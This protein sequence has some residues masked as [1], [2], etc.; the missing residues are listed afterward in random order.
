MISLTWQEGFFQA[1]TGCGVYQAR[2]AIIASGT[3]PRPMSGAAIPENLRGR[4][5]HEIA[6]L[7][8]DSGKQMIIVGSG[9]AAFDYA[10]NLSRKNSVIILNRSEQVKC[11]PKLFEQAQVNQNISYRPQTEI[12]QLTTSL[13]DDMNVECSSPDGL[14]RLKADILIAAV[15]REPRL[16]FISPS[17][18][19]QTVELEN[20]ASSTLQVMLKMA[21]AGK[22][23]SRLAMVSV[24]PCS[25][26]NA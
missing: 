4:V 23:L 13:D 20:R 18:A 1:E 24:P 22:L 15:G 19:G 12:T 26:T 3:K 10:L 2:A 8:D 11:L 16:D 17:L 14:I 7:L 9:D 5:V 6:D 21:C 25:S